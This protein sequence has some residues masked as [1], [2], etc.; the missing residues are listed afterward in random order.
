MADNEII[1]VSKGV[2]MAKV[3]HWDKIKIH[4]RVN[5]KRYE[6]A[7]CLHTSYMCWSYLDHLEIHFSR[8]QNAC[9]IYLNDLFE[10][11]DIPK[12][13]EG[14]IFNLD[15]RRHERKSYVDGGQQR[16]SNLLE[17]EIH[18]HSGYPPC[19]SRWEPDI[20]KPRKS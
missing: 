10:M 15:R 4:K 8:R 19:N 17:K 9:G 6:N 2:R 13:E 20:Y 12:S 14:N 11:L 16:L 3:K 5:T 7:D 18:F 1:E